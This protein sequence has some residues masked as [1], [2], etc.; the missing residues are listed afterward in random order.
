MKLT[1]KHTVLSCYL[2]YISSAA[3]NNLPSLLFIIF[4]QDFGLTTTQLASLVTFNFVTQI[5]VD[6]LG[7]KYSDRIGYRAI[8][9][10]SEAFLM[11]GLVC[12]G[13]LPMI[14][15]NK[16]I[17][18]CIASVIYAIGSGLGEV[19][20]SPT[21]EALP[22]DAKESAMSILHAFY[23]WGFVGVVVLSTLY[24]YV[25]GTDKWYI[26]PVL[27]A[28]VPLIS[29]IMFCIVPIR[30]LNEDTQSMSL[31]SLFKT[32]IFW[33]F[34]LLMICGGAAEQAMG[35]WASWFAEAAL[36]VSKTVGNLLG[37]CFFALAMGMTRGMYGKYA[38]K[39]PIRK[40]LLICALVAVC[41]YV[42]V[43]LIPN[44]YVALIGCGVIGVGVGLFWPGILSV[45]AKAI[46][47]GGTAMFAILAVCGDIGCSIG[48]QVA[49]VI[50][51][52]EGSN[53]SMGLLA[54]IVFPLVIAVSM[55]I[56]LKKHK[57]I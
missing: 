7:A 41:G 9:I 20:I 18:L 42:M 11:L 25:F 43:S 39:L 24:F 54:C 27:W 2:A 31:S 46:P 47:A 45:S 48:P 19:I 8:A 32:K 52:I 5:I 56:Y 50:S 44:P 12:V 55:S 49:A 3:A 33:L 37:P 10:V 36:G 30:M 35:Q 23:C 17:A 21:I 40:G 28:I 29:L 26:L 15:G 22:G 57:D 14:M 51:E 38:E 16:Y 6:V 1:Y 53:L 4:Q 13:I 34:M